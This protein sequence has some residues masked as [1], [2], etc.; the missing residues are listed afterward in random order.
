MTA[1]EFHSDELSL[2][3]EDPA[4]SAVFVMFH[5]P[6]CHAC[7]TL[8]PGWDE[9]SREFELFAGVRVVAVDCSSHGARACMLERIAVLPSVVFFPG[10]KDAYLGSKEQEAYQGAF[11]EEEAEPPRSSE[12]R[13]WVLR[14]APR[15]G[16]A[17]GGAPPGRDPVVDPATGKV[18][19]VAWRASSDCDPEGPRR[20]DRDLSCLQQVLGNRAGYCECGGGR[21]E[22]LSDCG[23]EHRK[24]FTCLDVCD[25]VAGCEGWKATRGCVA[26]TSKAQKD[27]KGDVDCRRVVASDW[28]GS[29]DCGG[30]KTAGTSP[31]EAA[32]SNCSH[33]PFT[34]EVECANLRARLATDEAEAARRRASRRLARIA[35]MNAAPVISVAEQ[36]DA[37]AAAAAAAAGERQPSEEGD[38]G[39]RKKLPLSERAAVGADDKGDTGHRQKAPPQQEG[40]RETTQKNVEEQIEAE[41]KGGGATDAETLK[42]EQRRKALELK[43]KME[44]ELG[45]GKSRE[46]TSEGTGSEDLKEA[47][48]RKALELKERIQ[49]EIQEAKEMQQRQ[50]RELKESMRRKLDGARTEMAGRA[51]ASSG[52]TGLSPEEMS[53]LNG[54][55]Q[56]LEAAP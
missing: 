40:R 44:R 16:P 15:L 29:C 35:A 41:V 11:D 38:Y 25:P 22:K 23:H 21:V 37:F 56:A 8:R 30:G 5:E 27:P 42:E 26:G 18:L 51:G 1:P 55:G 53:D 6:W 39:S 34:C 52:T 7:A 33:A 9:L 12:L 2:A 49:R 28:S 31:L 45:G 10:K 36:L 43:K 50:A 13:S 4:V 54:S 32:V 24:G 19:C 20:P 48:R 46:E 3:L 47:Q 17:K 14:L